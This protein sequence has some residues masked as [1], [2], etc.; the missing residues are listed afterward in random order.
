MSPTEGNAVLEFEVSLKMRNFSELQARVSRGEMISPAEMAAKYHPSAADYDKVTRWLTGRGLTVVG[1]DP[2]HLAVFAR[3][4]VRQI[5]AALHTTFARVALEGKEYSSAISAPRVPANLAPLLVGVHGLQPHI[6]ARKH[7]VMQPASASAPGWVPYAPFDILNAYNRP[8]SPT[9]I[10]GAGQSIAIVIDTFPATSDLTTFWS[11]NSVSQSLSNISF[12]QVVAGTLP[13]PS[14]EETLDTEWTSS[15]APAAKVRLYATQDLLLSHVDQAYQQ[16]YTDATTHPEYGIHQV[17]LSFGLGESYITSSQAQTDD[18]YFTMLASAGVTVFAASGDGGSTPDNNGGT[19]GPTQAESPASDPF[20]TGVGG[21]SLVMQANSS[22]VS[23]E[24][25]W[26]LGGGGTS[27]YFNRPAWQVGPGVP[28]GSKRVVPDVAAAA[29]P[30]LGAAVY[31]NGKAYI[32]GGTSWSCPTWAA[33]GAL[34][35]QMRLDANLTPL[36][37]LGTKIYPLMGTDNLRDITSGNNGFP[38]GAG[39]DLVT[40]CGV[41]NLRALAQTLGLFPMTV[42]HTFGDGTVTNDGTAPAS[43]MILGQDG[44]FYGTTS[45]GGTA[46]QGTVFKMTPQGAI[47]I[48]HHFSDGSVTHDGAFPVGITQGTD[49]NFYGTTTSGGT[50]GGSGNYRGTIFKMTP[51]GGVTILHD[52]GSGSVSNDGDRPSGSMIQATD[53]NFYGTTQWGGGSSAGTAFKITP[54]GTYTLLHMFEAVFDDGSHPSTLVQG[55]DGNFYGTTSTSGFPNSSGTVFQM[56]PQGAI[57]TLHSFPDASIPHDAIAPAGPLVLGNDGN[58]YGTTSNGGAAGYGNIFKITPQ[59][60]IT[61]LHQFKDG[62][63]V[64]DGGSPKAGLL[65]GADG[66][67]YGTTL[68]GGN[69][70]QGAIFK[71]T[72]AGTMTILHNMGDGSTTALDWP[73]DIFLTNISSLIQTPDGSLYGTAGEVAASNGGIAFKLVQVDALNFT[74]AATTTFIVGYAGSFQVASAGTPAPTFSATGL[75]AWASLNAS[76]GVISGTPPDAN[77]SPF[78]VTVTASNGSLPNATQHFTLNVQPPTAPAITSTPLAVT[79]LTGS[80]HSFTCQATGFPAPTFIV[81]SGALPPG[82][83]LTSAGYLSG[84]PSTGGLYTGTISASNGVGSAATQSFSITVQQVAKFTSAPLNATM[85]VG[86]PYSST[87]QASG[88]PSPTISTIYGLPQGITLS[89]NG[90]LSGTPAAGSYGTYS[91]TVTASNTYGTNGS[92]DSQSYAITVQQAPAMYPIPPSTAALS[93]FY[94]Y[95]F[96]AYKSGYPA[97]T[98]VLT[99][100]SFPPGCTMTSAGVLSGTPTTLGTYSGVVT[101]TNGIGS[102]VTMNFTLSVQP[103]SAP[104]F[105]SGAPPPATMNVPYSFTFTAAGAP[106]VFYA[107]TSGSLPPGISQEMVPTASGPLTWTGRIFGTPTQTG[108]YTFTARAANGVNPQVTTSYTISVG[109]ATVPVMPRWG[110]AALAALLMGT[111]ARS[112]LR[113]PLHKG[114]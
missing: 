52:F 43:A 110:Y 15:I 92:S 17:S 108:S 5:E 1:Q 95:S 94:G 106:T 50:L 113:K 65:P 112:L 23:S 27:V 20:V 66:N 31:F 96:A 59:G 28:A 39:Y 79:Y 63:V 45:G 85:T 13:A 71:M 14:G 2:F 98:F 81:A 60:V 22:V 4:T 56:T 103:A 74:S 82:L 11:Q 34:L 7:I 78:A 55:T 99:S 91:G 57:T 35:N 114:R 46:G 16:I 75:P 70:N 88:Y 21:T 102:P 69:S 32:V 87:F 12:I 48:L 33:M 44:N 42:L 53:G 26:T 38:A 83:S 36:G 29:D 86:T 64:N 93:T 72:P 37:V 104:V 49:G 9:T 77:G 30:T 25:G 89:A 19:T 18:Q 101:A 90:V 10:T 24:T 6:R 62:S 100:G 68:S 84:V 51:Q 40:G 73:R 8:Y 54:Q 97:P 58:F 76:T 41:P 3:G 105:T 109:L 80:A 61:I 67:F 47:T 111:A 107:L